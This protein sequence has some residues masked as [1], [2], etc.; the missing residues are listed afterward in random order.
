MKVLYS[1]SF[2]REYRKLSGKLQK[3]VTSTV[4][5]VIDVKSIDE[6]RN[7]KRLVGFHTVYRLRIGSLRAFISLHI[8]IE[9]NLVKF[10][11]L[12]MRGQAYNKKRVE[13]L[14]RIDG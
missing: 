14:K 7:C 13:N 3:A 5:E 9:G 8:E 12:A 2:R 1:K 4:K 6:L 10:Q 11:Y